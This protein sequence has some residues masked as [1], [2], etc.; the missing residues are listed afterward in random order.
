MKYDPQNPVIEVVRENRTK[1]ESRFLSAYA[2]DEFSQFGED[3]ITAKIFMK[4]LDK[5][6][7]GASN[8]VLGTESSS[9]IRTPHAKGLEWCF[10]R[11]QPG[12]L[13]GTRTDLRRQ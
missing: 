8:L 12:T 2:R 10:H 11:R 5:D 6:N 9:A 13:R 7:V 4:L 1:P 3:R